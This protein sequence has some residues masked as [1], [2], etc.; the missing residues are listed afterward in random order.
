MTQEHRSTFG[1]GKVSDAFGCPLSK[2]S[3]DQ[4]LAST[5]MRVFRKASR[6]Q[7]LG[8]IKTAGSDRGFLVGLS[9]TD[10]HVRT[11]LNRGHVLSHHFGNGAIY[12]RDLSEDYSADLRGA[13]DFMLFEIPSS[14]MTHFVEDRGAASISLSPTVGSQDALLANLGRAMLPLLAD[15]S[16]ASPMFVELMTLAV[17]THLVQQYGGQPLPLT[18]RTQRLSANQ[19]AQAKEMLVANIVGEASV[20][21]IATAF[22]L[23]P[24]QFIRMFR[25]ST[26][27]TPHRW[28]VEQ[29]ILKAC[30]LLLDPNNSLDK[31]AAWCGFS[32]QSHFTRVF[33]AH[34]GVPPGKWRRDA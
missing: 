14:S 2:L 21:E 27:M 20:T 25:A 13:F 18:K 12:V 24:S 15:P 22:D 6:S 17:G 31:I 30:D 33:S 9:V 5:T 3:L 10:G 28:L 16:R 23:S 8:H 7:E 29:R 34:R 26:G 19:E 4:S 1:P 32:D 11:M